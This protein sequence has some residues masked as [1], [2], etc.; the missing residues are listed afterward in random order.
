MGRD[1]CIGNRSMGKA[2]AIYL[3]LLIWMDTL[4]KINKENLE[5]LLILVVVVEID[6]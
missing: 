6:E 1:W 4:L 2:S 3:L 5:F